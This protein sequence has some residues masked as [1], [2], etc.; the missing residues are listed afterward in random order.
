MAWAKK[1][2]PYLTDSDRER[3]RRANENDN[4]K[5]RK[6]KA[7]ITLKKTGCKQEIAVMLYAATEDELKVKIR[8]ELKWFTDKEPKAGWKITNTDW[9]SKE[10]DGIESETPNV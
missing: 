7:Q 3:I 9:L 5:A 1:K 6:A 2:E 4:T 10:I 8:E